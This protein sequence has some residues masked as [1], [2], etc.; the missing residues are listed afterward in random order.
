[1]KKLLLILA[2][3]AYVAISCDKPETLTDG[4]EPETEQPGTNPADTL[5]K[6]SFNVTMKM[7]EKIN[8]FADMMLDE[9]TPKYG[10]IWLLN[11]DFTTFGDK[12]S[13][14]LIDYDS[15]TFEYSY[16]PD[17]LIS[18]FDYNK[19]TTVQTINEPYGALTN[20]PYGWYQIWAA[21]GVYHDDTL[22]TFR[23]STSGLIRV[24]SSLAKKTVVLPC[25][26]VNHQTVG[27]E[28]V[29]KS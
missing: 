2:L 3:L 21:M 4:D 15:R 11:T 23:V 24:D 22:K 29:D 10:R 20:V 25:D 8:Q 7:L 12:T 16:N 14:K 28:V 26:W 13:F 18:L 9:N 17:D 1:M 27:Y 5:P 6:V 19:Y